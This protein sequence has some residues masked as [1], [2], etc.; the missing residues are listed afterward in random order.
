MRIKDI[1]KRIEE[2]YKLLSSCNLCGFECGL[3]RLKGELGRCRSGKEVFI[4]S[5]NLH[6]G[7]EPPISGKNGSGTVFFTNCCLR[8]VYCQNFPISQLGK[9]KKVSTSELSTKF[10]ELQEKGAHNL[11]L[12]TPTHY[13]PQIIE[14]LYLA[15]NK[16]FSMPVVYN[17]SG[18]ESEEA[19]SLLD[20]VIDIYLPDMRYSEDKKASCF[21][22][23]KEYVKINRRN[24][25][26]MFR[27]V[28]NLKVDHFGMAC[29]GLIVRHLVLPEDIAG[30]QS[31]FEF[32]AGE[33]SD[34]VRVSLMGQYFPAYRASEFPP[35][36]RRIRKEEY[37]LILEYLNLCGLS[38]GWIQE[39]EFSK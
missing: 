7:E 38:S 31:T 35:L 18:Y 33:V 21:S 25:K 12:V 30:S 9:G 28:G 5:A 22:T 29:S 4:A 20:G 15:W 17:T 24:I 36:D 37:D 19:L 34:K 32:L 6:F 2:G 1:E 26:E 10:L 27:Q 13:I 8:C 3:N 23:A 14:A 16:G 39:E 11:N